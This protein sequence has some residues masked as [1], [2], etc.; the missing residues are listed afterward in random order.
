MK[1]RFIVIMLAFA[2]LAIA[3][4]GSK[5][6]RVKRLEA[7]YDK[8]NA[9]YRNDCLGMDGSNAQGVNDALLGTPSK[10]TA[11]P[12][13]T[14]QQQAKC[15]EEKAKLDPLADELLKAQQQ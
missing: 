15:K 14:P 8:L 1:N 5:Q 7:E 10:S 13:M 2:T 9:Q 12:V 11:A 4:C 6:A 3:G